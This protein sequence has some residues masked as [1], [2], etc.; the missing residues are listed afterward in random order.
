MMYVCVCAPG[1]IGHSSKCGTKVGL[2]A[3]DTLTLEIDPA[4]RGDAYYWEDR[5]ILVRQ[6]GDVYDVCTGCTMT[7]EFVNFALP[8]TSTVSLM[9]ANYT[10][11][12]YDSY[13]LVFLSF[14]VSGLTYH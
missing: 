14:L 2:F 9:E 12:S 11:S 10:T 13:E 3:G 4:Y 5:V 7:V 8:F 1:C 6:S